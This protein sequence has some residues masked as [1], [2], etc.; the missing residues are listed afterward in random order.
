MKKVKVKQIYNRA[1]EK[2]L[3]IIASYFGKCGETT[4]AMNPKDMIIE[5]KTVKF[6]DS[7]PYDLFERVYYQDIKYIKCCKKII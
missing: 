2:D 4:Y 6:I 3:N 1:K 7:Y 5:E